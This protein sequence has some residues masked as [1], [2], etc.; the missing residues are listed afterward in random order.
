LWSVLANPSVEKAN[1][2]KTIKVA[3]HVVLIITLLPVV[4]SCS[5]HS[6]SRHYCGRGWWEKGMIQPKNLLNPLIFYR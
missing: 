5:I 2:M 1:N 4:H 6:N 3:L